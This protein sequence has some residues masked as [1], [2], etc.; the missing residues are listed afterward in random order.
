MQVIIQKDR[1]REI[2]GEG[3]CDDVTVGA[4][5]ELVVLSHRLPALDL[6]LVLCLG[7]ARALL[8]KTPGGGGKVWGG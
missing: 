4:G 6:A 8:L 7:L 5:A 2:E 1:E 3:D